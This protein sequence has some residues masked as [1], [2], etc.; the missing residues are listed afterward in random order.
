MCEVLICLYYHTFC[1]FAL[2]PD[3]KIFNQK[4]DRLQT[5]H[6]SKQQ[7]ITNTTITDGRTDGGTDGQTDGRYQ[8]YN[9]P[10][11]AVDKNQKFGTNLG[12]HLAK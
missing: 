6:M 12:W 9:L 2:V 10:C 11:F 1:V 7:Q 8:T 3:I 5:P 4:G